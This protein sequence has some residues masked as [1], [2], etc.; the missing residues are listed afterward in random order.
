M[1]SRR[2]TAGLL[3]VLLI[4]SGLIGCPGRPKKGGRPQ[5]ESRH[6]GEERRPAFVL[7]EAVGIETLGGVFTP[8]ILRG[9]DLPAT[10]EEDFSTAKDNQT[11]VTVTLLAGKGKIA[12]EARELGE[13]HVEG[14]APAPRG[15][16]RVRITV[17]VNEE[18]VVH[19]V[20]RHEEKGNLKSVYLGSVKVREK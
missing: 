2:P 13:F 18:G 19:V 7:D 8:L 14:I 16:P 9:A 5:E 6:D 15:M 12:K 17:T 4:L 11:A 20:A 1:L 3:F 10:F